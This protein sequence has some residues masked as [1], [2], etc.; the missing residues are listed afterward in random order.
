[1]RRGMT[2][3]ELMLA[4]SI[5]TL[6]ASG[7]AGMLSGLSTGLVIGEEVRTGMLATSASHRRVHLALGDPAGILLIESPDAVVWFGDANAGGRLEP[8]EV[9]WLEFDADR[10]ELSLERVVFPE[11]WTALDRARV[12][13][14]IAA[15]T[16][17][18]EI[19]DDLRDQDLIHRKVLADGLLE[20]EMAEGAMDSAL[21]FDLLFDLRT[22][23]TP[24]TIAVPTRGLRPEEWTP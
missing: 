17:L 3:L 15:G 24:A 13:R 23:H 14:P 1:M 10:G 9:G 20:A 22:V 19:R 5:T 2:L 16:D 18:R 11:D 12:D 6:V 7:I 8:S 21:R 4:I